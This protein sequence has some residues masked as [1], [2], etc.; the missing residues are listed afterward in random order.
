MIWCDIGQRFSEEWNFKFS[1]NLAMKVTQCNAI[2]MNLSQ[3]VISYFHDIIVAHHCIIAAGWNCHLT[4]SFH[5]FSVEKQKSTRVSHCDFLQNES[6]SIW[7][8]IS[9]SKHCCEA[10]MHC[11]LKYDFSWLRK[12]CTLNYYSLFNDSMFIL[13]V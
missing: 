7:P 3:K 6:R 8:N 12:I 5:A 10:H 1:L 4:A 13:S 11:F 9:F 2:Y